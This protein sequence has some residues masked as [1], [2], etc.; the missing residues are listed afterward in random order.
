MKGKIVINQ[1]L[2]KGCGFCIAFCPKGGIVASKK[3]NAKGYV[4]SAS[5][6]RKGCTGCGVCAIM[7]PE[8]AIEVYRE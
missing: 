3:L 8:A 1:E 4:C 7:C 2:C 6:P 5:D